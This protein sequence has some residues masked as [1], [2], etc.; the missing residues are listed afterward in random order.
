MTAVLAPTPR[1]RYL[2]STG[3]PLSGGKLYSYQSGSSTL[4]ATYTDSTGTTPNS[5]PVILDAN[6]EADVWLPA[7]TGYKFRLTDANDVTQWTV[8]N[9]T[10][11]ASQD[12]TVSQWLTSNA[13]PT[14]V[15]PTSFSVA[16]DKRDTFQVNRRVQATCTAGVLYG[17][18]TDSSYANNVTT[19]TVKMDSGALDNGLNVANV[20]MLTSIND[21]LPRNV[22]QYFGIAGGTAD[23][24]TVTLAPI[25]PALTDG[26][27]I[28]VRATAANTTTTPT[29]NVNGLGA[30]TITKQG[31]QALLASDILANMECLFRFVSASNVWELINPRLITAATKAD[32]Q[33]GTSDTPFVTPAHQQEH[34]SAVKAWVNFDGTVSPPTVRASYNV[35]SV[36]KNATGDYTITFANAMTDANYL[37]IGSCRNTSGGGYVL[38]MPIGGT[39]TVNAVQVN[40]VNTS[41]LGDSSEINVA[42]LGN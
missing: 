15:T 20:G 30:K 5:N 22:L 41:A 8:D 9:I 10:V 6:G 18:I 39:K 28:H 19:V 7:D 32:Q 23:A 13:A 29:L 2:D 34:K 16:G 11:S 36:T 31:G 33:A 40:V 38:D 26:L 24:L 17:S 21:A 25:P 37:P 4:L 35:S 14:Y 27:E 12:I 42:I 3:N 1:Q